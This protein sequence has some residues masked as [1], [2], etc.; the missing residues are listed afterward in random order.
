MKRILVLLIL[1]LLLA[2]CKG[3]TPDSPEPTGNAKGGTT[4]TH[5]LDVDGIKVTAEGTTSRSEKSPE[6]HRLFQVG[7][8][9]FHLKDGE[10]HVNDKSYGEVDEGDRV[11]IT[12][13]GS[14][15]VNGEIRSAH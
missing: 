4:I 14:V 5:T 10:L 13:D 7:D 6:G 2:G 3:S 8:H 15:L 12:A 1:I 11:E 9:T